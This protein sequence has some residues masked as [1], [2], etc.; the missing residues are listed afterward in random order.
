MKRFL[1]L[2]F[3]VPLVLAVLV[4]AETN[5]HPVPIYLDP[6]ASTAAEGAQIT[7]PLFIVMLAAIMVGVIF[8][9]VVTY[10]EQGKYRRAARRAQADADML[11]A[12]LGRLSRMRP[13]EKA[14]FS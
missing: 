3:L 13:G 8:G 6:L 12:E 10:F 14:K 4:I 5:R 7:V 11:R 1:K 9:S 2:L